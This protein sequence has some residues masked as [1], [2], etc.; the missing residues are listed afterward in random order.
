SDDPV[1]WAVRPSDGEA[2]DGRTAI[3]WELDPGE[4]ARDHFEVT[5]L[6]KFT[7]EFA[8]AAA[9]GYHTP[10]GRFNMLPSDRPSTDAGKW[11]DLDAG[12]VVIKA[13]ESAT[14]S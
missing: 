13:G 3:E 9:D 7:V 8:I 1:T 11:I 5:N 12:H 14:V 2:A 10:Q 6:S 4:S